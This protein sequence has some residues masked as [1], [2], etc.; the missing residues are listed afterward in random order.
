MTSEGMN[1]VWSFQRSL[2]HGM[3]TARNETGV[4]SYRMRHGG[5][6]GLELIEE[7]DLGGMGE[8]AR[9][10]ALRLLGSRKSTIW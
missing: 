2:I 4:V 7:C 3:V 1:R 6:G 5:E 10:S 8:T 9:I